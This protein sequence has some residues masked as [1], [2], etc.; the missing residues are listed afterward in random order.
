MQ[1]NE[2]REERTT[3]WHNP[4]PHEQY[5]D[6]VHGGESRPTRYRWKPG[7]TKT[8]PSRYDRVIH[9]VY[10]GVIIGGSAPQLVNL[11]S[12]AK[13][14]TALDTEAVHRRQAEADAAAA[15]LAKR[16]A[17]EQLILA[18]ARKAA[19]EDAEAAR[20]LASKEAEAKPQQA[21][22]TQEP[23][24]DTTPLPPEKRGGKNG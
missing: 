21:A 2:P 6:I 24:K 1:F 5:V 12:N 11:G 9:T 22:S 17:E 13:L 16:A 4:L 7:E 19:A 20:R 3:Q 10:N 8:L 23:L 15:M 14:D 18:A